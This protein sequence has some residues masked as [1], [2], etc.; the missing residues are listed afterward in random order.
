MSSTKSSN[1]VI[2]RRLEVIILAAGK[3]SRMY[4]SKPKVLHTLGGKVLL[5]HV[6]DTAKALSAASITVVYGHGGD[7]VIKQ[8]SNEPLNWCE[9]AEQLGPGHA[10]QQAIDFISDQSDVLILYG[11]VPLLSSMTLNQLL[12]AK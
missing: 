5:E 7:Q 8:L 6:V 1:S 9:Q 2:N 3:G 11:D 12:S 10:V 4:S